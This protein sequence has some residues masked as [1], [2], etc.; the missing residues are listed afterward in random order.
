VITHEDAERRITTWLLAT[1]E[2]TATEI[3]TDTFDVTRRTSQISGIRRRLPSAP[4]A[5]IGGAAAVAVAAIVIAATSALPRA[6]ESHPADFAS[7]VRPQWITDGGVAVTVH[8]DA[9]DDA[10]YYWRATIFDQITPT[11]YAISDPRETERPPQTPILEG[12]A[13]DVD[14]AGL[15]QVT[16]T[17]QPGS[18]TSPVVLAPAVPLRVAQSTRLTT[19]GENGYFAN[20]EREGGGPYTVTA[21]VPPGPEGSSGGGAILSGGAP[22]LPS[23]SPAYPKELLNTYTQLPAQTIGPSLAALRDEIVHTAAS[24]APYDLANR[25]VEVLDSSAFHYDTDVRDVD[26][27]SMSVAECFATSKHGYC[28]HFALAM[29]VLLRD[30][31]IPARIVEGF[32]PGQLDRGSGTEVIHDSS[33]HAWVEAYFGAAGW[34]AFDPTPGV[35]P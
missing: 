27:G 14:P 33:A 11:G 22:I 18:F 19:V 30:L 4:I 26:C 35:R 21:L 6:G 32:L 3:L 10:A 34:V 16:F 13:D 8:R 29:A 15:R 7:I 12:T 2:S 9:G 23:A 31:G 5:W 20:L 25:I 1:P 24:Q 28:V 17:I